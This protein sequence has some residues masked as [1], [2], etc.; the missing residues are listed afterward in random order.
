MATPSN[1]D[2]ERRALAA[3]FRSGGHAQPRGGGNVVDHDGKTY[4]VL[5]NI[6]R[7]LAV[8]RVRNDGMLKNLRRPPREVAPD[9]YEGASTDATQ[10]QYEKG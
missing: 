7:T 8:Y 3:Y 2:L 10:R 1:R 5:S 6:N 4:V 9:W